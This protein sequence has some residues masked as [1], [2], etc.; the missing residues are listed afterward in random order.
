MWVFLGHLSSSSPALSGREDLGILVG[1]AFGS[2]GQPEMDAIT[3][4]EEQTSV[5]ISV[6]N[7]SI[8]SA[9]AKVTLWRSALL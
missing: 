3:S 6:P 2:H 9:L 5:A 8:Y 1:L 4:K 7:Y